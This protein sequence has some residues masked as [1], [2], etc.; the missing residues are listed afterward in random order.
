MEKHGFQWMLKIWKASDKAS[1]LFPREDSIHWCIFHRKYEKTC[2]NEN[3]FLFLWYIS[4]IIQGK[5]INYK[6]RVNRTSQLIH[7]DLDHWGIQQKANASIKKIICYGTKHLVFHEK[8]CN[9][10]LLVLLSIR[11]MNHRPLGL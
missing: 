7:T 11:C 1:N 6:L 4:C 5:T 10:F 2:G 8:T 9:T 3:C